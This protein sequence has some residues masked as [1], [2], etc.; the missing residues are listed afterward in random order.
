[1][2]PSL[3]ELCDLKFIC[4]DKYGHYLFGF[5]YELDTNPSDVFLLDL[6]SQKSKKHSYIPPLS[7]TQKIIKFN[8]HKHFFRV[9]EVYDVSFFINKSSAP[10][11]R[12][13]LNL[14]IADVKRKKLKP[15]KNI[16]NLEDLA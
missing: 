4:Q 12:E 8:D 15:I 1:M 6:L 14:H 5:N 7:I 9:N 10:N 3:Y 11:G 16:V 2:K 13:Y